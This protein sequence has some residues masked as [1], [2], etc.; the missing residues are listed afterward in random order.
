VHATVRLFRKVKRKVG[1]LHQV[2]R[3][4]PK[5]LV[6]NRPFNPEQISYKI[7]QAINYNNAISTFYS[8]DMLENMNSKHKR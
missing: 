8:V 4:N 7:C 1:C 6:S 5:S 2:T 3:L